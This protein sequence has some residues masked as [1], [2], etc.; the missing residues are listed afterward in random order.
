MTTPHESPGPRPKLLMIDDDVRWSE[1]V[2]TWLHGRYRVI[3][4]HTAHE[5]LARAFDERPD[6][7]LLDM[8]LPDVGG[9]SV[10]WILG[11]DDRLSSCAVIVV[12]GEVVPSTVQNRVSSTLLKPVSKAELDVAITRALGKPRTPDFAAAQPFPWDQAKAPS[13]RR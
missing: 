2:R 1:L 13:A 5:G 3:T 8:R 4:S 10:S 6:V 12:S 7:I 9:S 11:H